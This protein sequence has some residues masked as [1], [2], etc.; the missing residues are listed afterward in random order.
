MENPVPEET[1]PGTQDT[2]TL[3]QEYAEGLDCL[4]GSGTYTGYFEITAAAP[5]ITTG[6]LSLSVPFPAF[7]WILIRTGRMNCLW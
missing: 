1:L 2:S 6:L 7:R 4:S 5:G 3:L